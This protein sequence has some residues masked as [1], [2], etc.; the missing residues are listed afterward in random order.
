MGARPARRLRRRQAHAPPAPQRAQAGGQRQAAAQKDACAE[1]QRRE[2]CPP[3]AVI[4]PSAASAPP[5]S[6]FPKE[7]HVPI[8]NQSDIA[9]IEAIALSERALPESSYAALVDASKRSPAL[10]FFLSADR[11]DEAHVWTY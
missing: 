8:R 9:A 4:L 6:T 7:P 3:M 2:A 11:L 1:K 10:S 5:R